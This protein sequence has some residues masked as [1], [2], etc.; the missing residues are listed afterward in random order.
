[1][2][3]ILREANSHSGAPLEQYAKIGETNV[4]QLFQINP[5]ARHV[6]LLVRHDGT[7]ESVT[8][9]EFT[10]GGFRL[11]VSA[12]PDLGEEVHIRVL[13]QRDTPGRIRWAHGA[14]AGGSFK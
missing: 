4:L 10:R 3:Q 1:M 14:E 11:A 8:I 5:R 2:K 9:T 6:A 13:G 7:E 12:R